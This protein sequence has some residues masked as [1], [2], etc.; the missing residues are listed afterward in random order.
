MRKNVQRFLTG[1]GR[2]R[3]SGA[4]ASILGNFDLADASAGAYHS[5]WVRLDAVLCRSESHE[6]ITNPDDELLA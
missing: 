4:R 1:K 5:G 6:R 3:E 2:A